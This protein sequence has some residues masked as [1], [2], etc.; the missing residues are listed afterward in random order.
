[1]PP[2]TRPGNSPPRSSTSARPRSGRRIGV[3]PPVMERDVQVALV[4]DRDPREPLVCRPS[5]AR[6]SAALFPVMLFGFRPQSRS[7]ASASGRCSRASGRSTSYRHPSTCRRRRRCSSRGSFRCGC[8]RDDVE[9]VGER[10]APLVGHDRVHDRVEA[11][12]A[13]RRHRSR[14]ALAAGNTVR[15][16]VDAAR[17]VDVIE[18]VHAASAARTSC[19]RPWT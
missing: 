11:E 15:P 18:R 16:A 3:E 2:S 8:R 17:L 13:V 19:R 10:A 9:V 7:A 12:A 14:R 5:S 1:M 4:V 6:G